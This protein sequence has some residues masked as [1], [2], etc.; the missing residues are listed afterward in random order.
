MFSPPYTEARKQ[1]YASVKKDDYAQ[2]MCRVMSAI[3]PALRDDGVVLIIVRAHLENGMV[4]DHILQTRL[5]LRDDGWIEFM[6]SIWAKP[7]APFL[8]SHHRLRAAFEQV[9]CFSKTRQPY[10]NLTANG[11]YSD[12]IGFT[13]AFRFGG[14]GQFHSKRPSKLKTGQSRGSDVFTA[15]VSENDNGIMHPAQMPVALAERLIL[16]FTR[17]GDVV[18]DPFMGSGSVL[19]AARLT[20]RR[21]IGIEINRNYVGIA[22][23]RLDATFTEHITIINPGQP[24]RLR[25]DFPNTP[26]SRRI[27]LESRSLNAS[28]AAVFELILSMTVN[29]SDRKAAIELSHNQIVAATKLSRRTVIRSIGRLEE[30]G[31]IETVK[32]QQWHRGNANRIAVA[33]SLLVPLETGASAT[34]G[35]NERNRGTRSG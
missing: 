35:R 24:V 16:Q 6:E 26:K 12:R 28:D 3:R 27:Y 15:H 7:D 4:S 20:N 25:T 17:E 2:W 34:P 22:A 13:G 23:S 5:A 8:G 32:H 21:G 18:C 14:D 31:F 9:L 29:S 30:A 19:C 10:I 33:G 1:H 11:N